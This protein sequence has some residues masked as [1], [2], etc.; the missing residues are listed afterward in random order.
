MLV[1]SWFLSCLFLIFYV[2]NSSL[3]TKTFSLL[4]L[5]TS[6]STSE[7]I[8]LKG[9]QLLQLFCLD[10]MFKNSHIVSLHKAASII[11][12]DHQF[13]ILEK[14]FYDKIK[15]KKRKCFSLSDTTFKS[16][17]YQ[18]ADKI[19]KWNKIFFLFCLILKA[20]LIMVCFNE[21]KHNGKVIFYEQCCIRRSASLYLY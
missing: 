15:E 1:R 20:K 8:F 7:K 13:W 14:I 19:K 6:W 9:K 12:F 10:F 11:E 18:V 21:R 2:P 17:R 3:K 16:H 5:I 4:I